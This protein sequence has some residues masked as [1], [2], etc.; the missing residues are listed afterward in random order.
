MLN[1]WSAVMISATLV[2]R[3]TNRQTERTQTTTGQLHKTSSAS[4]EQLVVT[5][6]QAAKRCYTGK[7]IGLLQELNKLVRRPLTGLPTAV[8][9]R[10]SKYYHC[11]LFSTIIRRR[12]QA[13]RILNC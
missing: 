3:Q 9:T 4:F 2:N 8:C 5:D 10:A 1:Y 11:S 12:G 7:L 13:K 6:T